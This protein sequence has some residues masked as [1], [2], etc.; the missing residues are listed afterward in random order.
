[1]QNNSPKQ[2]DKVNRLIQN[3]YYWL[4]FILTIILCFGYFLSN[5]TMGYYDTS[6]SKVNIFGILYLCKLGNIIQYLIGLEYIPFFYEF[7]GIIIYAAGIT[8]TVNCFSRYIKGFT[9]GHS[10]IFACIAVSFPFAAIAFMDI[11]NTINNS[12]AMLAG[13]SSAFFFCKYS[14][15]NKSKMYLIFSI[16]C[17]F[18][19]ISLCINGLIYFLICILFILFKNNIK[20]TKHIIRTIGMSLS[21]IILYCLLLVTLKTIFNLGALR[22]EIICANGNFY[23]NLKDLLNN[24]IGTFNKDFVS[25]ILALSI[26]ILIFISIYIAIKRKRIS[27]FLLGICI[28]ILPLTKFILTFDSDLSYSQ[29]S[30]YG[31]IIAITM[32]MLFDILGKDKNIYK[33]LIV[34]SVIIVLNNAREINKLFYME[35]LKFKNDINISSFIMRDLEMLNLQDKPIMF[36]GLINNLDFEYN[37]KTESSSITE[38]IFNGER[39]DDTMINILS[40]VPHYFINNQGKNIQICDNSQLNDKEVII[41]TARSMPQYPI[42]G[43][44]K[45]MGNYVIV[46]LGD[47]MPDEN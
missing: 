23:E 28:I 17:L 19:S 2:L 38:S 21:T 16:I 30:T 12:M 13:V 32:I 25:N 26:I 1:M 14:F 22:W 45:D 44:I 9:K 8:L 24:F 10:M 33:I 36:V 47:D 41:N 39:R 6:I 31:F 29:Y 34:L 37:Y 7:L 43:Y 15:E 4:F 46:K 3:F 40:P 5:N 35:N 20:V 11:E 18:Y 27:T 42:S